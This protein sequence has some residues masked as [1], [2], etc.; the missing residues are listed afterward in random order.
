[1]VVRDAMEG[2]HCEHPTDDQTKELNPIIRNAIC[3]ALHAF[4]NYE[5]ADAA[6]RFVDFNFRMIPKHWEKPELLDGY[7]KMWNP[8]N[9]LPGAGAVEA[10]SPTSF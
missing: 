7:V 10:Q 5:Q 9:N 4:N 1:M 2:F 8:N 3:T 6:A